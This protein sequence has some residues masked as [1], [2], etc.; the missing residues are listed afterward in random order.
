MK[1][2]QFN[3][4]SKYKKLLNYKGI[5]WDTSSGNILHM[6]IYIYVYHIII[7]TLVLSHTQAFKE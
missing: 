3:P 6:L 2:D 5:K 7:S 4:K 1:Q